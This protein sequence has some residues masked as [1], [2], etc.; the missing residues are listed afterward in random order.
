MIRR[1]PKDLVDKKVRDQSHEEVRKIKERAKEHREVKARAPQDSEVSKAK[2]D[3]E[4]KEAKEVNVD[5]VAK[6]DE[7]SVLDSPIQQ[8]QLK[9]EASEED[10]LSFQLRPELLEVKMDRREAREARD[11]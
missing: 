8:P 4:D 9:L 2:E 6:V 11:D 5:K 3:K 7:D 1:E 10:K